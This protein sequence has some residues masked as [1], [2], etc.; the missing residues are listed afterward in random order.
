MPDYKV[1]LFITHQ[2]LADGS[3]EK[4]PHGRLAEWYGS[5]EST[6]DAN[7]KA[8]NSLLDPTKRKGHMVYATQLGS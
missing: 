5:A 3:W 6:A 2:K 8:H 7:I 4:L 1:T